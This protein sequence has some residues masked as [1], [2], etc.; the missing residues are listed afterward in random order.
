MPSKH[1]KLKEVG[2]HAK[3]TQDA[4]KGW[5][6]CQAN[7]HGTLKEVGYH[8]KQT[9]DAKKGWLSCQANTGR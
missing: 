6:S 5:L 1:W 7:T 3:Q 9:R 2:Y 8:A 4:K